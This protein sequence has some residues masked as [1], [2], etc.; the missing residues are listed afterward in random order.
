MEG[1][2]R[3]ADQGDGEQRSEHRHEIDEQAGPVGADGHDTFDVEDLRH[4]RGEDCRV[5]RDDPA[6]MVRPLR[7]V[8]AGFPKEQGTEVSMAAKA[9]IAISVRQSSGGFQRRKIV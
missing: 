8:A 1:L 7:G 4:Q 2:Q 6:S 5:E 3:L 9:G